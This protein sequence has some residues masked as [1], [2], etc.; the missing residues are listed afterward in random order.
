[1]DVSSTAGVVAAAVTL[2]SSIKSFVDRAAGPLADEVG[3]MLRDKLR[4][5]RRRNLER[6]VARAQQLLSNAGKFP[7]SIPSRTLVPIIEG[8]SV[9]DDPALAEKWAVLLANAADGSNRSVKPSYANILAQLTPLD[10]EVLDLTAELCAQVSHESDDWGVSYL[11]ILEVLSDRNPV[12]AGEVHAALDTLRGLGLLYDEP[13]LRPFEGGYA[14]TDQT[15][16]LISHLGHAFLRAC[17]HPAHERSPHASSTEP[18]NKGLQG[19][20]R[21]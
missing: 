18:P 19:T 7:D 6:T 9:E 16:V 5:Y 2:G 13:S 1:M 3:E 11:R 12:A 4:D 21:A 20:H 10:A 8:A 14:L 15:E 17:T